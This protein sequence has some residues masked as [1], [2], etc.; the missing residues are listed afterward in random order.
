M[1]I[2]NLGN[3]KGYIYVTTD[4]DEIISNLANTLHNKK[5]I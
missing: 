4:G 2:S 3:G 5:L 1:A